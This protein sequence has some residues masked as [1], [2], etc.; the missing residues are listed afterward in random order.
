MTN[1]N[2]QTDDYYVPLK[3][4]DK[5]IIQFD[6]MTNK[7]FYQLVLTKNDINHVYHK[8]KDKIVVSENVTCNLK[9]FYSFP[10]P[11]LMAD[12]AVKLLYR[13]LLSSVWNP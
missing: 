5:Q 1:T 6:K 13:G 8:W 4:K 12:I 3:M 2:D 11:S 9:T 10:T 7:N